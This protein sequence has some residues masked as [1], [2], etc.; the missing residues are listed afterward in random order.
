MCSVRKRIFCFCSKGRQLTLGLR[1]QDVIIKKW[2]K[3]LAIKVYLVQVLYPVVQYTLWLWG[4][5]NQHRKD[6]LTKKKLANTKYSL[7]FGNEIRTS[8][9]N[10][11]NKRLVEC[12]HNWHPNKR[13]IHA[14]PEATGIKW[15][16]NSLFQDFSP[17]PTLIG[18][19]C[20]PPE[21]KWALSINK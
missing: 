11:L 8:Y 15:N 19:P 14:F 1:F 9:S 18:I 21:Q 4:K 20:T 10:W 17:S 3:M 2:I 5:D 6:G 12:Y 16:P 7:I 13:W